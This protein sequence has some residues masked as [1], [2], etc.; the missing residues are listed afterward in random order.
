MKRVAKPESTTQAFEDSLANG[1]G[2]EHYFLRLF[3]TGSTPRSTRAIRNIRT[4]CEEHLP[5]RYDLEVID[6]H[7]HPE[8][9]QPE[10]IVVTPTLFKKLPLPFRRMIG[11]LS[12][13]DDVLVGLGILRRPFLVKPREGDH[14]D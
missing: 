12:N 3:V 10:Q 7:Q 5:G 11:D 13:K 9:T 4:I 14:G 1:S 2:E 8:F 6:I